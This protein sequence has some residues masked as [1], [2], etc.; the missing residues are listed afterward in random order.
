MSR[1]ILVTDVFGAN[2]CTEKPTLFAIELDDHFRNQLQKY[3]DIVIRIKEQFSNRFFSITFD[4]IGVW[5]GDEELHD[6]ILDDRDYVLV[7]NLPEG[8]EE[9]LGIGGRKMTVYFNRDICF[10]A[11]SNW[12]GE[13]FESVV[14][15]AELLLDANQRPVHI[16]HTNGS[17]RTER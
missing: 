4:S 1:T 11:Y 3:L 15:P 16:E 17:A 6:T 10:T 8:I 5:I 14:L 9:F 2:G 12:S 13:T 7:D